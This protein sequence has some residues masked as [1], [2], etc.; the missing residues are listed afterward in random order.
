MDKATSLCKG[1]WRTIEEIIGWGSQSDAS[2]QQVWLQIE[3]RKTTVVF[4]KT[5]G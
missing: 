5:A 2:K 1:C 3:E 4:D